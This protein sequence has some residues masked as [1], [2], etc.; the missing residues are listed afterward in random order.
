MAEFGALGP[1]LHTKGCPG[2]VHACAAI[3][4]HVRESKRKAAECERGAYFEPTSQ[5]QY[6]R[7]RMPP[8]PT[9]AA[10]ALPG[11]EGRL[12]PGRDPAARCQRLPWPGTASVTAR[13]WRLQGKGCRL[14]TADDQHVHC[15]TQ[16]IRNAQMSPALTLSRGTVLIPAPAVPADLDL[17]WSPAPSTTLAAVSAGPSIAGP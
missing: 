14:Q 8:P 4:D 15:C 1:T 11:A 2:A 12:S 5:E 17:T 9:A 16:A 7:R 10:T 6:V 3:C 13:S